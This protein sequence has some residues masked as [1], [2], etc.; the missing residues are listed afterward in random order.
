ML[1]SKE[2]AGRHIN[3]GGS[4]TSLPLS[5]ERLKPLHAQVTSLR[6]QRIT[7]LEDVK[8][9]KQSG[10]KEES[11]CRPFQQSMGVSSRHRASSHK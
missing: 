8:S 5:P 1:R 2:A 11:N 7:L 9:L 3:P 6:E 4:P 10:F